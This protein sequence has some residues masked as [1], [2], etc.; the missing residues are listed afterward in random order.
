MRSSKT[1]VEIVVNEI[2][3]KRI[4]LGFTQAELSKKVGISPIIYG[5]IES[6]RRELKITELYNLCKFLEL[7]FEKTVENSIN[8]KRDLDLA[9]S[10]TEYKGEVI[11]FTSFKGGSGVSTLAMLFCNKISSQNNILMID[12]SE[13][14]SC[15]ETRKNDVQLYPE[16]KPQY[17]IVAIQI[18]EVSNY[19]D[20]VRSNFDYII[21]DLPQFW[22]H[23]FFLQ[24]IFIKCDY[25]FSPF[26]WKSPYRVGKNYKD[27]IDGPLDFFIKL[28]D[29]IKIL[30]SKVR[31]TLISFGD[32]APA[33]FKDWIE[34]FDIYLLPQTFKK[35][36]ELS[37]PDTLTDLSKIEGIGYAPYITDTL[38]L[39]YYLEKETGANLFIE[40]QNKEEMQKIKNLTNTKSRHV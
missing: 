35:H 34:E 19:I 10:S 9:D 31:F 4:Q 20:A 30:N 38:N 17:E 16:T 29:Q 12:A 26:Y 6:N 7:P 1:F 13:F 2:R 27:V 33:E 36:E 24:E 28:R 14:L 37:R 23:K 5:H 21:I 15:F 11:A 39:I 8:K 3:L 22:K 25:V 32:E 40:E 18:D